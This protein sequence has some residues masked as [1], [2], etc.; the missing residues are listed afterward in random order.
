VILSAAEEPEEKSDWKVAR[1]KAGDE[2]CLVD[3]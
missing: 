1:E 2:A 3:D